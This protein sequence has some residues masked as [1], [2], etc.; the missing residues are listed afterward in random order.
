M[1]LE[2][3]KRGTTAAYSTLFPQ[4]LRIFST[5]NFSQLN[6]RVVVDHAGFKQFGEVGMLS[7]V[8]NMV[9]LMLQ[10]NKD[11]ENPILTGALD[12]KEDA[13]DNAAPSEPFS[14]LQ[15]QLCPSAIYCCSPRTTT[16]YRVDVSNLKPVT[17][18]KSAIDALVMDIATKDT[19][20]GLV[21]EH[22]RGRLDG[23][24]NDFIENKGQVGTTTSQCTETRAVV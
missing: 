10:L 7:K 14:G 23:A 8:S 9:E 6:E 24:L 18:Q 19:L 20:R 2:P 3:S 5:N 16:W 17:W 4:Y 21:E 12:E 15:A 13:P 1:R 22:K 11:K